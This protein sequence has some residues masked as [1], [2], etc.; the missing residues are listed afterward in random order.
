MSIYDNFAV[1]ASKLLAKY[2]APAVITSVTGGSFDPATGSITGSTTTFVNGNGF[3]TSYKLAEID[4]ETVLTNDVKVIIEKTASAP[5]VG[6]TCDI[7]SKIYRIMNVTPISPA[8]TDV[9]YILQCR[10]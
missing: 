8:G 1:T 5:T 10:I 3:A 6:S 7:N 2:G 4:G 9:I